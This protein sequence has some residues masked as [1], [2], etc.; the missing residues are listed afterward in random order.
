[1][2][3]LIKLV[4]GLNE[5][6]ESSP[7]AHLERMARAVSMGRSCYIVEYPPLTGSGLPQ[8]YTGV[9][10]SLTTVEKVLKNIGRHIFTMYA[11]KLGQG[12]GYSTEADIDVSH[13]NE[14]TVLIIDVDRPIDNA[15]ARAIAIAHDEGEKN[16]VV[17]VLILTKAS[18]LDGMPQL[19]ARFLAA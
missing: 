9:I 17:I 11:S 18:Y 8:G 6:E 16:D 19:Q 1:M 14:P 10:I 3:D 4:E 13:F 7:E 2:R 5:A 12:R 15:I